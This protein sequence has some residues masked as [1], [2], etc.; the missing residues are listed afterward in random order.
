MALIDLK[1]IQLSFGGL[2]ILNNLDMVIDPGERVCLL[3][4]NGEGKTSLIKIIQ[5]HLQPDDGII[6]RKQGLRVGY[7][8]QE[9]PGDTPGSVF[10]VV[11]GGIGKLGELLSDYHK[12]SL[13]PSL[14]NAQQPKIIIKKLYTLINSLAC[15]I[16]V[17]LKIKINFRKIT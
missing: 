1:N 3:G 9:V 14:H 4:R 6:Q 2:P 8:N 12:L 13:S 17:N 16:S 7:L 5:G 10:E 15:V 11:S